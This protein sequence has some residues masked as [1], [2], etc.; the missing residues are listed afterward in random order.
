MNTHQGTN[1][2]YDYKDSGI[3]YDGK[4]CFIDQEMSIL[5][6]KIKC[7]NET[8]RAYD[9]YT[10]NKSDLVFHNVSIDWEIVKNPKNNRFILQWY[11]L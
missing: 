6:V 11:F 3:Y 4:L 10:V 1:Q 2:E 9:K 7:P 8:G 5:D